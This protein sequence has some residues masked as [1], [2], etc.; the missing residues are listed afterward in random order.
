[1]IHAVTNL[2]PRNFLLSW[3][4]KNRDSQ[5]SLWYLQ[6][7]IYRHSA[8]VTWTTYFK[9]VIYLQKSSKYRSEPA[10]NCFTKAD[11]FLNL[12]FIND[13]SIGTSKMR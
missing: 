2:F 6:P 7:T 4:G 9:K 11:T 5:T 13:T 1:M 3:N 10:G 8:S 12:V